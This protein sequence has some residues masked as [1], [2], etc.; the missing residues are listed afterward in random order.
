MP[1][2]A[3]TAA[4]RSDISVLLAGGRRRCAAHG[5]RPELNRT[6]AADR[7]ASRPRCRSWQRPKRRQGCLTPFVRSGRWIKTLRGRSWQTVRVSIGPR[8]RGIQPRVAIAR[9]RAT[10]TVTRWRPPRGSSQRPASGTIIDEV[11]RAL[12]GGCTTR[13]QCSCTRSWEE[14]ADGAF[15][16][17]AEPRRG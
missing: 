12:C 3:A 5:P 13:R 8:R 14:A 11:H 15:R 16:S 4:T 2:T 7:A 10:T 9:L 6:A 17:V 1:S